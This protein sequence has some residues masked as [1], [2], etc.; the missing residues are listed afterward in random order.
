MA[1]IAALARPFLGPA[2]SHHRPLEPVEQDQPGQA[3]GPDQRFRH[4][5]VEA[6]L[7]LEHRAVR[8]NFRHDVEEYVPHRDAASEAKPAAARGRIEKA[9]LADEQVH[10]AKG[11]RHERGDE[12]LGHGRAA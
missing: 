8:A 3:Q 4:H 11:E 1:A 2:R 9:Q 7:A 5:F 6:G 12:W 10:G